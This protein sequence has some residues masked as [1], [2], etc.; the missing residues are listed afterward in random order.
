MVLT[1]T[2]EALKQSVRDYFSQHERLTPTDF[3]AMTQ[4]SR[5]TAIPL[6]EWLDSQGITRRDGDA[7]V[8]G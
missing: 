2:L 8:A 3:K 7:R 6:L 5:R 4:L 1:E